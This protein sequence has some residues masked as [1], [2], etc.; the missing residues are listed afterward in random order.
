MVATDRVDLGVETL[1]REYRV[2]AVSMWDQAPTRSLPT[3][4]RLPVNTEKPSTEGAS[5]TVAA[6]TKSIAWPV[7]QPEAVLTSPPHVQPEV[8]Q[9]AVSTSVAPAVQST[10]QTQAIPLSPTV[11]FPQPTPPPTETPVHTPLLMSD[12]EMKSLTAMDAEM[13]RSAVGRT[14]QIKVRETVLNDEVAAYVENHPDLPFQSVEVD[15]RRDRVL[16][17]GTALVLKFPVQ[18][19]AVGSVIAEDC[20]PRI[21]VADISISGVLTPRFVKDEIEDLIHKSV[22]WYPAD[23][24]LCI[25]QIVLEEDRATVYGVRR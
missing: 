6:P 24:A 2:T 22:D 4:T 18:V 19:T 7:A 11:D 3:A 12:P 1:V 9:P 15:L 17:S 10:P 16:V 14:V 20:R 8:S 21:E 13:Q 25:E 23:Y 5:T